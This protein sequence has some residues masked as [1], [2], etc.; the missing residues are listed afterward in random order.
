MNAAWLLC[1]F[2][3][4]EP[5]ELFFFF[6]F[7][8]SLAPNSFCNPGE[9]VYPSLIVSSQIGMFFFC[10]G[11]LSSVGLFSPLEHVSP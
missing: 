2:F 11:P 4:R 10:P 8:F 1:P 9:P 6:F 7:F 3:F 5:P